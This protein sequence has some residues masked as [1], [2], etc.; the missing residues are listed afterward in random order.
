MEAIAPYFDK[1]KR[2]LLVH[3][4]FSELT[5]FEFVVSQF[6]N[7]FWCMCPGANLY[8]ENR[9]PDLDIFRKSS[10]RITLGTDSL[11]S[12]TGLDMLNE[13]RLIQENFPHIPLHEI[14]G[15]ATCNGATF[16]QLD[17]QLGSFKVGARPGVV[18]VTEIDTA[19][20]AL[21]SKSK[22]HLII[23]PFK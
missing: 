5:D 3:N 2:I 19:K 17:H 18:H 13:I 22:S 1:N 14:F 16:L 11:A 8:I 12:N 15:W 4:T 23:S 9:L 7:A 21:T 20:I 6:K 10:H